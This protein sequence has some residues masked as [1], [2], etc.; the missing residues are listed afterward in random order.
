MPFFNN[1]PKKHMENAKPE[2]KIAVFSAQ[3]RPS[4]DLEIVLIKNKYMFD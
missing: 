2:A 4:K 1:R 3:I